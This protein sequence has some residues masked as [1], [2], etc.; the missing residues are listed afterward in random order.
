MPVPEYT[1]YQE[2]TCRVV[3]D[4]IRERVRAP[5]VS[6]KM[7]VQPQRVQPPS[8]PTCARRELLAPLLVGCLASVTSPEPALASTSTTNSLQASA[9]TT[10]SFLNPSAAAATVTDRVF[11][12]IRIIQRYDV[13]VLEDAAI[14][15]RLT[16]NL[17]G[18]DAPR[19]T[20]KFLDFVDGTV[21]QFARSG[22]GPA[23]SSGSFDRLRPS[24]QI[25]G[26]RIAGLRTTS[27]QGQQEYEYLGRL[28]PLRPV[29]E[30]NE[31]RHDRRGLLTRPIFAPGKRFA[32]ICAQCTTGMAHTDTAVA[33]IQPVCTYRTQVLSLASRWRLRLAWMARTR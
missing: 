9:P 1:Q 22:G 33:L 2:L 23:Y 32:S 13:E 15:G 26:G 29:L 8:W 14:R 4:V 19:G 21:G 12:D 31:V 16:F 3:G 30:V 24:I 11:L 5:V 20:R 28:L 27:F 18:K 10:N 25:E 6:W 7:L 17:F